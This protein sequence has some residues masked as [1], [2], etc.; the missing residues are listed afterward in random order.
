MDYKKDDWQW[1]RDRLAGKEVPM[2]DVPMQGFYALKRSAKAAPEPVAVWYKGGAVNMKIGAELK[3]VE[4]VWIARNPITHDVYKAVMAGEPWPHEVRITMADGRTDSTLSNTAGDDSDVL[5]DI[6]EWT[7]RATRA[8]KKGPPDT[9]E[10]AD[11]LSD[12]ATK[13][14]ELYGQADNKRLATTL[15]LRNQVDEINEQF[16]QKIRPAKA[17]VADLK[18]L[19]G[20]YQKK[21]R[22][23]RAAEAAKLAEE[24]KAA[25]AE[26]VKIVAKPVRTGTRGK[27]ISMV[28]TAIVK[29][30]DGGAM[31]AAQHLIETSH[32][33][34][35]TEL[36]RIV[37]VLLRAGANV[38]G[39]SIDYEERAR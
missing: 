14:A 17:A 34:F 38:P 15:P 20:I 4:W 7:D 25:G 30:E 5:D 19:V 37:L 13:L 23:R 3:T 6:I 28:K 22:D 35:R 1:W 24:A 10:D 39:A 8:K 18:T 26:N 9:Q 27:S 32:L 2:H 11:A 36:D 12:I 21:E 33:G 29:Y 16:N 31:K